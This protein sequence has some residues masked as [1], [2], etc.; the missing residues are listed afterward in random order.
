MDKN[1]ILQTCAD[2]GVRLVRFLYCDNG[3]TIRGKTSALRGLANRLDDGIGLT[4]AMMAMN[5]FDVLQ[6]V[7]G[8]GAAGEIRLVPDLDS[9]ALLPY[10]ASQAAL[11][12]DMLTHD[13]SPWG[14]CPRS[15]LKHMRARAAARGW[16][17][18]ASFEAEFV[19]ALRQPDGGYAP[20]DA[21]LCFSSTAMTES[22]A[23]ANDLVA[24]L[25]GQGI[26]VEQYYPEY[27]HGQHEITI[28]HSEVL[29][30]ADNQ[31]KLR[32]TIRSVAYH[33]ELVAA[34]APK[35]FVGAVGN[36]AHIHFSLW[37]EQGRNVFYDD[38]APDGLALLGRQFMAG[39]LHHLPA[40]CALSCPSVNSYQRLQPSSWSSAFAI[41]GHDNR[42]A[43]L[44]IASPFWSDIAGSTNV[45]LKVCDSS[46]NP[47]LALGALLACGLDGIERELDPG[48]PTEVDPATLSPAER[49]QRGIVSLPSSLSAALDR[50]EADPL[51][52]E[53]L[54]PVLASSYLAVRRSEEAAM[55]DLSPEAVAAAHFT[56]Y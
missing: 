49:E 41:Y 39:V 25:E 16:S 26:V 46:C 4:V 19:L 37:D 2:S 10:V 17:L 32:E 18:Q 40:L 50:L 54:G 7:A 27:G 48:E 14:G 35:P 36:G 22:A 21:A 43:A 9:F 42:E 52:I 51:L 53:A 23:F 29:Q 55:A 34:L 31:I 15:F 47:Y 12:C 30:A 24:A 45:E 20:A 44:R 56:K 3:G 28:R 8:M 11:S 38:A 13:R 6:P 33:H 1:Q 5:G